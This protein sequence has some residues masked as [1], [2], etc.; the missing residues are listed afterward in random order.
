MNKIITRG[1]GP[2]ICTYVPK[3]FGGIVYRVKSWASIIHREIPEYDNRVFPTVFFERETI[4]RVFEVI[5]RVVSFTKILNIPIPIKEPQ[6]L[7]IEK[8]PMDYVYIKHKEVNSVVSHE[9]YTVK[10]IA[11]EPAM[12]VIEHPGT[13]NAVEHSEVTIEFFEVH[14]FLD[15]EQL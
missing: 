8:F 15:I 5:S 6:N 3:G 10:E 9:G 1:F 12:Y 13:N 4:S 2:G 11:K 7:E 14:K